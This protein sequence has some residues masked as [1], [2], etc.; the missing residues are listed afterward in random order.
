MGFK[1]K[2]EA[3][4][5]PLLGLFGTTIAQ[6][7][8]NTSSAQVPVHWL[9]STPNINTGTTFG[10]PWAKGEYFP[11]STYLSIDGE[12]DSQSWVTGYWKD[13]SIK[14]SAHALAASDSPQDTY[15]VTANAGASSASSSS[16]DL[17]AE[18]DTEITVDTGN[19]T[20]VFPRSGNTVVNSITTGSGK[21]VGQNG[22]LVLNSQSGIPGDVENRTSSAIDYFNFESSIDNVTVSSGSARALVTMRGSHHLTSSGE[23]DDWLPFVLRF[24]LYANSDAMRVIHTLVFDGAANEDFITGV[25]IRFQVPLEGEELYNRHIRLS[26]VDDGLLSE[27]VQGITG[28]RRDPGEEIRNA[29]FEGRETP[30]IS[31]WDERVSSRMQW[32][33]TWNDYSLEQLSPDGFTL[34]KRTEAGQ[35]WLKIPGSTRSGGLAYLGGATEGGLAVGLRD[36]W[37]RY[38]TGLDIRNAATD[39]GEITVWIYSPA[40][41][42]LDLRPYHGLMG[43]DTYEEQ[44]DALEITY[45]DYEPGFATPFG[46]ARTNELFIYALDSTPPQ[47]NLAEMAHHMNNPPVLYTEPEYVDETDALGTYW[48]PPRANAT[49]L[50]AR[51]EE[52][53]DFLYEFYQLQKEQHKWYGFLDHGDF[54]HTYDVD[55]HQWRYDIG[56]Y[57]W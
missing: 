55:R 46:I 48:S 57:A 51:I 44:L 4:T 15:T 17:V 31:T 41:E 24:Y 42:P 38:P 14:W 30:D 35:S 6:Q 1:M 54:M 20:A 23:H 18:S 7:Y 22:K 9:G 53:M 52:N 10:L 26:G 28:L 40:A 47:D 2:K 37:Q 16:R 29:Q 45:E 49:G 5:V 56:G 12:R 34:K 36:F 3:I 27:A 25:G 32:I 50:E 11:N 21:L 43:L 8:G 19:L 13:G 33:P 39:M